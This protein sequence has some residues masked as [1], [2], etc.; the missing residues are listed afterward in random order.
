MPMNKNPIFGVYAPY[1]KFD[2][3][4]GRVVRK[5]EEKTLEKVGRKKD[6]E[7]SVMDQS[8][9]AVV[10]AGQLLE[11]FESIVEDDGKRMK[12]TTGSGIVV[13][14]GINFLLDASVEADGKKKSELYRK[15][16]VTTMEI[17]TGVAK[18][19]IAGERRRKV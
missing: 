17:L 14:A 16:G 4:Y 6:D 1:E 8:E 3:G 7:I 18:T 2:W 12:A 15:G 5:M 10:A 13:G 19:L 11:G 9:A